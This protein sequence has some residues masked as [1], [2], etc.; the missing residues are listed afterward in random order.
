MVP[1]VCKN[2]LVPMTLFKQPLKVVKKRKFKITVRVEK[3]ACIRLIKFL[4]AGGCFK[5]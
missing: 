5:R 4:L 1:I 2:I 3:Y